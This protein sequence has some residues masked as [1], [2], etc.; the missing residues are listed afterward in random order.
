MD[1][2]SLQR[3]VHVAKMRWSIERDYRDLKQEFSLGY[4]EGRAWRGYHNHPSLC[5]AAYRFL[6]AQRLTRGGGKKHLDPR[7]LS[8]IQKLRAA[9]FLSELNGTYL[10][11]TLV[12]GGASPLTSDEHAFRDVR[13]D[14]R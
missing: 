11:R 6:V 14:L 8:P 1:T 2:V 12:C 4:F 9:R 7:P 10:I 5:I 3:L 13:V